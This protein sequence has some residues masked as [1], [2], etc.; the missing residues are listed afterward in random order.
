MGYAH[1]EATGG[2]MAIALPEAPVTRS[3]ALVVTET[4][5]FPV[6]DEPEVAPIDFA[7]ALAMLPAN[8]RPVV[9]S[10]DLPISDS[11]FGI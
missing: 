7:G 4:Q 11:P 5:P 9:E 3:S 6:D 10:D 2:Q 1:G 8:P